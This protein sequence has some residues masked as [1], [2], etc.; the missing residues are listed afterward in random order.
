MLLPP[1]LTPVE[2]SKV[3][4][5][6]YRCHP[7]A[8]VMHMQ[9][10]QTHAPNRQTRHKP[11]ASS[12]VPWRGL[13]PDVEIQTVNPPL[14]PPKEASQP[15]QA[16]SRPFNLGPSDLFRRGGGQGPGCRAQ[17]LDDHSRGRRVEIPILGGIGRVPAL[18]AGAG[19]V[20]VTPCRLRLEPVAPQVKKA[21]VGPVA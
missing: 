21:A 5:E 14:P 11:P 1:A 17:H 20:D 10:L 15:F 8:R 12:H 13:Q 16:K 7:N 4:E 2:A 9:T 6:S 18:P 19:Q 3:K